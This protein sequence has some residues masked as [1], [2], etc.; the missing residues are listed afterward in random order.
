[1]SLDAHPCVT[2]WI[3]MDG[4]RLLVHTGKVDIG[5]R[6]S[7]ALLRIVQEELAVPPSKVG[8][9][10]VRTGTA[11]DEGI[12]SGSNSIE[13]S[14]RAVALAAATLRKHLLLSLIHI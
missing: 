1:M 7:N 5:Q 3:T 9:A 8:F 14:G 13:Q 11:P 12:T 10:P 6:I 2:D 4:E